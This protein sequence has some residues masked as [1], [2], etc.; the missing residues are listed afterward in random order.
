ALAAA[1]LDGLDDVIGVDAGG[2]H[3][4]RRLAGAGHLAYR[5]L[6]HRGQVIPAAGEGIEDGVSQAPLEPVVLDHDQLAARVLGGAVE[7]L[8]V[9]RLDRI[10]VDDA[11]GD[12]VRLEPI[13]GLQGFVDGDAGGD[14]GGLIV[15]RLFDDLAAAGRESLTRL[16]NNG[17]LL[18]GGAQ[19]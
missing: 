11:Y 3:Q 6:D 2:V 7:R 16:V 19:V 5:Q 4:L 9:D 13:V 14:D 15:R 8:L 17:R 18:A 1:L 10:G 12:A